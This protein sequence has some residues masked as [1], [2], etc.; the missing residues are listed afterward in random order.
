MM[1][2]LVAT[3]LLI[4][5]RDRRAWWALLA[6]A[7]FILLAFTGGAIDAA[8]GNADKA[9]IAAAERS[10][11]LNQGVKDPHSAAHY[12]IFAFKPAPALVGLDSGAMPFV[13]QAVWL[14]AHHQN[15]L[16][17]RPQ[18]GASLLQRAGLSSP[19]ALI[20]GIGP[21]IVFLLAFTLVA[22]DREQGTMR[23]ALGMAAQ[24][25]SLVG[26]KVLAIWGAAAALLV[27]PVMLA[28]LLVSGTSGLLTADAVMRL[29]LWA[30]LMIAYLALPAAIGVLVSLRAT[31]AR[32]AL[33]LLFGGWILFVLVIP[34]AASN[35]ADTFRPLP[36]SQQVQQQM[37]DE[38]PAYWSA[39]DSE[40]HKRELLIRYRVSRIEDIPNPRMA[41]LDLVERQSHR[42]FDRILGGFYGRVA[43]Q[44][45]LFASLGFLSP[46]IAGQALSAS[47]A[48]TDFS[49]QRDF[50]DTAERYRRA[51]VNCMNA[52]GMAHRAGPQ[53]PHTNDARLWSEI[54]AFSYVAPTLGSQNA[55]ALPA[56]GALLF[57][58]GGACGLL[59]LAAR[60]IAP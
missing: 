27:V 42:V 25:R 17:H 58:L 40:R 36:S 12:S 53:T 7:A 47:L 57:W 33:A 14:E 50:I 54:P 45:R 41:E 56:L 59:V 46:T 6:L 21:L 11:W 16:L 34:R 5:R 51:L 37:L 13:G 4:L 39:A 43:G 8:R 60:K 18:Q 44:D 15:D 30:T 24:P 10:R 48:G 26:S 31:S 23:L 55:T 20:L 38:A 29:A 28:A 2:G 19:A 32:I 49:H 22:R 52:D 3:E 1:S 9:G 35:A